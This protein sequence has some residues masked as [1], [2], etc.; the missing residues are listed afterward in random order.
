MKG[1][2]ALAVMASCVFASPVLAQAGRNGTTPPVDLTVPADLRPLLAPHRSE[3]RLVALR[4]TADRQLLTT[5]YAGTG[6]GGRGGGRGGRGGGPILGGQQADSAAAADGSGLGD[7][8]RRSDR[9]WRSRWTSGGGGGADSTATPPVTVSGGA[10]RATQ[11]LRLVLAVRAERSRSNEAHRTSE[12][13]TRLAQ[14]ARCAQPRAA[15]F[16]DRRPRERVTAHAVC[17]DAG[18]ARRVAAFASSR[19]TASRPPRRSPR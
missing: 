16:P 13:W 7:R 18:L 8:S 3:V 2:N 15:R 12:A 14:A 6:G 9:R 11:A 17:A 5:N 1:V 19:S 4:Y 10:H